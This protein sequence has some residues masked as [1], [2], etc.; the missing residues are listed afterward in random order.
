MFKSFM[1]AA[2]AGLTAAQVDLEFTEQGY[3]K[4]KYAAFL[5][6]DK[7]EDSDD[8][9]IVSTFGPLSSG[10]IYMVPGVKDAVVDGSVSELKPVKLDTAK[11]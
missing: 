11:F 10:H 2:I 8:F 6:V 4:L 1:A 5:S 9:M 7:F 3:F